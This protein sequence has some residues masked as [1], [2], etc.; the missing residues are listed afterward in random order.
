MATELDDL[1]EVVAV[2]HTVGDAIDVHQRKPQDL[3]R[4]TTSASILR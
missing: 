4:G 2:D 1:V 3:F